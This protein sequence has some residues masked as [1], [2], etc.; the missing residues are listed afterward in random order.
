M[1]ALLRRPFGPRPPRATTGP[2]TDAVPPVR[3]GRPM[4]ARR[5]SLPRPLPMLLAGGVLLILGG[6]L[7]AALLGQEDPRRPYWAM[8]TAL[9]AGAIIAPDDLTVVLAE[10]PSQ[11]VYLS[12]AE[13][14]IG[15]VLAHP[16]AAGELLTRSSL[17][18][19]GPDRRHVAIPV[20]LAHA[21][22]GLARGDL[23][24][25]W[26]TPDP[27]R[28]P[29]TF[30]PVTGLEPEDEG[31]DAISAAASTAT[32]TRAN[33]ATGTD[34]T[35]SIHEATGTDGTTGAGESGAGRTQRVAARVLVA[36]VAARDSFTGDT[37]VRLV[38]D[39]PAAE[40]AVLVAA[41]RGGFL[42]VVVIPGGRPGPASVAA[43]ST[44]G[45]SPAGGS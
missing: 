11:G 42:D 34:G 36:G 24:D 25:V 16:Q 28:A 33:E 32:G 39:V 8:A 45:D 17:A 38:L 31:P 43:P 30:L 22:E 29:S 44:P 9:G 7:G 15:Q 21:P 18:S 27:L 1:I 37:R 19:V 35:T 4:A 40:V 12:T 10:L 5:I 20:D 26:F 3:V 2:G 13:P 41:L 14:V 23:V 6:L